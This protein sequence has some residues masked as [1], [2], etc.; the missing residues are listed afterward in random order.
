MQ[1]IKISKRI[2]EIATQAMKIDDHFDRLADIG[3]D[4]GYLPY[5]MLSKGWVS[6][7]ILCDI[8]AGPLENA[9]QTFVHSAFSNKVD[10]RL[11]SGIKPVLNEEVDLLFIAGMGG[12]LIMDILSD[13]I[14]K[15]K[16]YPYIV[17]QPM[18]EQD[19][20][21]G[22]LIENGFKILWDHFFVDARKHYELI[23]VTTKENVTTKDQ[24]LHVS[25]SDYTFGTTIL[26]SQMQQYIEF[27]NHKQSKYSTILK[28]IKTQS[29]QAD[30]DKTR[31]LEEKLSCIERIKSN[32][33]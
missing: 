17:L 18:T 14:E 32:L 2:K 21:R 4:H 9:K 5:H 13:D 23:V 28:N 12:G 16:S 1:A 3:T 33:F 6:E 25:E 20:L 24:A 7:A 27:L 19:L 31:A 26:K 15:S 22:W 11:G 8:N 10:F 29:R 30:E